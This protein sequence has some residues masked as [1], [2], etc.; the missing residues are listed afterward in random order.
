MKLNTS[1][2]NEDGRPRTQ[3]E[4][5]LYSMKKNGSISTM[6]AFQDWGI[7]RL[8]MIIH[9]LKKEMVIEDEEVTVKNR[10][11][12]SC[13]YKRYFLP[14]EKPLEEGEQGTLALTILVKSRT[15]CGL[16][17][18]WFPF[19]ELVPWMIGKNAEAHI[20]AGCKDMC[21]EALKDEMVEA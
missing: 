16:C 5:V 14:K 13:T 10:F 11:G 6:E 15:Q 20:C 17:Y 7:T 8:A 19:K 12:F 4:A 3:K 21:L 1:A 18:D 2:P 9:L